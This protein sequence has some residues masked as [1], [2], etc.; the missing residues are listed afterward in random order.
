MGMGEFKSDDHHIYYYGHESLRRNGVA[1][2]FTKESEIE[3]FS[4]ISKTTDDLGSLPRQT[5]ISQWPSLYP[6]H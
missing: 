3:Y 4:A 5:S 6:N 2:T 1:F